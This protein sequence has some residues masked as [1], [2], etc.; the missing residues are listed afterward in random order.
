MSEVKEGEARVEPE[1]RRRPLR[2]GVALLVVAVIALAVLAAIAVVVGGTSAPRTASSAPAATSQATVSRT[3]APSAP[4]STKAPLAR[5]DPA[6]P[7]GENL[8]LFGSVLTKAAQSTSSQSV[9]A[10]T[11]T[12]ALVAAGFSGGAMQRTAD[13]TSANLQAPTLTV[14]VRLGGTCLVGQF[15]RQDASVQT[16]V[17]APIGTGACLI[18]QTAPVG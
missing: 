15:V 5:F 9:T 13:Q 7:D 16:E 3:A 12:D 17:A 2:R 4:V 14:S 11:L 18:G 6:A 10:K 8:T 1:G